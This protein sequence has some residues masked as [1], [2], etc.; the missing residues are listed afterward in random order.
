[1]AVAPA[2]PL[3]L[4]SCAVL[5]IPQD[6][7][8]FT[9]ILSPRPILD[10]GEAMW[11]NLFPALPLPTLWGPECNGPCPSCSINRNVAACDRVMAHT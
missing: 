6:Q 7:L 5:I 8:I 11:R 10:L 9:L 2:R 1:M 3:S 4:F